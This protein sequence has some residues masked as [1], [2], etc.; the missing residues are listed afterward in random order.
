MTNS[1]KT[2][3]E[4]LAELDTLRARI[5]DLEKKEGNHKR[6]RQ[7]AEEARGYAE[8]IVDTVRQPL[9]VLDADL[10]V[11]S[12]NRSFYKFF[13][14]S[15]KETK[16]RLIYEI[17]NRQWDI[18]KLRELFED[19][20]PR[21]T[22]F[23]DFEVEHEFPNIGCRSM[24]LN[25]RQIYADDIGTDLILVAIEDITERKRAEKALR[26]SQRLLLITNKHMEMKPLLNAF[27]G[28]VKRFTGCDA[29]GVR[30]LDDEGNIPYEAHTGF[31]ERFLKS[32]SLL[33]IHSDQ[34]MCINVIKQETNQKLP[35]YTKLGSF[36]MN[37]GA[38][39]LATASE[40]EKGKTC[41]AC[42]E[43]GYESM[44]LIPIRVND[45]IPGL[46]HI[47]DTREDM[48]PLWMVETL[49]D[50]GVQLG[51]GIK[52]VT[53]QQSLKESERRYRIL[54]ENLEIA[55]KERIKELRQS[56]SL[57][58]IGQMVSVIGHEIRN[59]LHTIQMGIGALRK[60]MS[61]DKAKSEILEE[62][63]YGVNTLNSIVKELLEYARPVDLEY[64]SWPIRDIVSRALNT[65][66]DRIGKIRVH[67]ELEDENEEMRVDGAK[68]VRVLS[69]LIL[70]AAEAMPG[71]GDLRILSRFFELDTGKVLRLSISD[72]GHGIDEKDLERIHEPFVTTKP[73]GTGLG[74][75]I[76]KKIIQ[77]HNG[78]FRMNSKVRE[79]TIIDIELPARSS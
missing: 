17:G 7:A 15:E 55:V 53:M 61:E 40:G 76:C 25:A 16:G 24:L 5:R 12:A 49:E 75:P 42:S 72:N 68:M 78:S 34:C 19:I 64:S 2:K 77:A 39:S 60:E 21:H 31:T 79:G 6:S 26:A 47:A 48:V 56:E 4:L 74:I 62:I 22:H 30:I 41:N 32:G 73:Q 37:R 58:S 57:A 13:G 63:D 45:H 69:N 36:Y 51:T 50:A 11:V 23:H 20:L 66:R 59:P 67:L 1:K 71:G 46:V 43:S 65:L 14:V 54:S 27:V 35:F 38:R 28:E 18:P 29:V 10:H 9:L 33:S 70:N 52:R 8:S 44:A 3:A